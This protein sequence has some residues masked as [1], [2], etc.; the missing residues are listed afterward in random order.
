VKDVKRKLLGLAS[1]VAG[2]M[3][4][5]GSMAAPAEAAA[6]GTGTVQVN[7][8]VNTNGVLSLSNNTLD[9]GAVNPSDS[10]IE[11]QGAQTATVKSNSPNWNLSQA[12]TTDFAKDAGNNK[13]T[14]NWRQSGGT[15]APATASDSVAT[16]TSRTAGSSYTLDYALNVPWTLAPAPYNANL[17][18]TLSFN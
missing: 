9:F 13:I 10:L 5:V 8:T 15:Y 7:A 6:A 1:L 2:L 12:L 11:K 3:L 14:L 17:T 16:I 4:V 18:Y